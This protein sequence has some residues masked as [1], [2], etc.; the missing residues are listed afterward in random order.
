MAAATVPTRPRWVRAIAAGLADQADIGAGAANIDGNQVAE[1]RAA[2]AASRAPTTPAAGP[3][4]A[5]N[6]R[7]AADCRA[8][9]AT[10]P[11]DCISSSGASKYPPS[12]QALSP[13]VRHKSP[14]AGMIRAFRM[15]ATVCVHIHAPPVARRLTLL[16]QRRAVRRA[17]SCATRRSSAPGSRTNVAGRSLRLGRAQLAACARASDGDIACFVQRSQQGTAVLHLS[18]SG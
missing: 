8:E 6:S 5:V 12:R 7:G 18:R 4:N 15:V 10:P 11:L 17:A 9:P 1:T 2:A 13:G 14:T 16:Q 3:D